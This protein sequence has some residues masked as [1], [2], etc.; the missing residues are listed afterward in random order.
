[1]HLVPQQKSKSSRPKSTLKMA[2]VDA[3]VRWKK[4]RKL[5]ILWFLSLVGNRTGYSS[6]N[7]IFPLSSQMPNAMRT[8]QNSLLLFVNAMSRR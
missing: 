1:M 7:R 4:N 3:S 5:N 6:A 2:Y 8:H